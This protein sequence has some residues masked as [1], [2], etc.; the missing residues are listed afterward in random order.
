MM[1]LSKNA[2]RTLSVLAIVLMLFC[3]IAFVVP[4]A[5]GGVFWVSFVF[6]LIAIVVQLY[7]LKSAFAKGD[8]AKSKFYGYP[9]AKLGLLYLAVQLVLSIVCMA[10]GSLLPIW[11]VVV[12]FVLL[13]ALAAIGFIAADATRD[14][15]VRQD[16]VL[17]KNVDLMRGLQSK[18]NYLATQAQEPKTAATVKKLA[19]AL[20]FSDPVSSEATAAQE[21]ELSNWIAELQNALVDNDN[22]GAVSICAKAEA[23]LAERNQLC[24]TAK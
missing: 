20:R 2:V 15:I 6:A 10:L 14:E 5:R 19:A 8:G 11:L 3:V 1:N 16:T 21:A 18:V 7:V 4:F 12:V 24:K 23:I 17:K 22:S 9:I 13:L